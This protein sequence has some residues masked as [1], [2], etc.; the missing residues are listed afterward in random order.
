MSPLLANGKMFQLEDIQYGPAWKGVIL[1]NHL[2]CLDFATVDYFRDH[3]VAN[4]YILSA[5][6][7]TLR[8]DRVSRGYMLP[9]QDRKEVDQLDLKNGD[10]ALLVYNASGEGGVPVHVGR[11][12]V[13]PNDN[14][15]WIAD[16]AGSGGYYLS[17]MENWLFENPMGAAL[18]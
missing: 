6:A 18:L 8:Q 17:A 3:K 1:D 12:V 11:V 2:D 16:K 9:L 14:S 13:N 5:A 10:I 7:S 4:D 15:L